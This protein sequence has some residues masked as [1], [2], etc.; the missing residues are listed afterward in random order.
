LSINLQKVKNPVSG[1]S[2]IR[3]YQTRIFTA[4]LFL[5]PTMCDINARIV[6]NNKLAQ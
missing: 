4:A 6:L 3:Q 5:L 2:S 1:G